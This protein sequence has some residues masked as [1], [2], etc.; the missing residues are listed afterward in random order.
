[1]CFFLIVCVGCVFVFVFFGVLLLAFVSWLRIFFPLA[2]SLWSIWWAWCVFFFLVL[3]LL[4]LF[5]VSVHR[6]CCYCYRSLY[7]YLRHY[8]YSYSY[9]SSSSS[10][11]YSYLASVQCSNY[12]YVDYCVR[13]VSYV[14]LSSC[15][16]FFCLS[17]YVVSL[18]SSSPCLF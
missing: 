11:H 18:S 13:F 5:R 4:Y 1:M 6:S 7:V 2:L 17:Y 14:Y 8:F 12:Q 16:V 10:N 3:F 9:V 15:Y